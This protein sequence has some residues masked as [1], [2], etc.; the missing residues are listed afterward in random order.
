VLEK[1][2]GCWLWFFS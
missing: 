1:Q 2:A